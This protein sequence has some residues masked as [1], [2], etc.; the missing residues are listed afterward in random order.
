MLSSI[1]LVDL[2]IKSRLL[3]VI[4]RL[5]STARDFARAILCLQFCRLR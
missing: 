3:H 1:N 5:L 2:T 4:C